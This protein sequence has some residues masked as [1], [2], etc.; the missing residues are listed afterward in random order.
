MDWQT[1]DLALCLAGEWFDKDGFPLT[2]F[3]AVGPHR[4]RMLTVKA[5]RRHPDFGTADLQFPEWPDAWFDAAGFRRIPPPEELLR[6]EVSAF[7]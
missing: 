6:Q 2:G 5:T 1:N 3:P 7:A 4:G